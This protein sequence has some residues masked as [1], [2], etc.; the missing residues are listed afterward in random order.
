MHEGRALFSDPPGLRPRPS[1]VEATETVSLFLV[2]IALML[3][4]VK[5]LAGPD[6]HRALRGCLDEW[7]T[8]S[9]RGGVSCF[10]LEQATLGRF[11][12]G[13]GLSARSS[14]RFLRE[15]RRAARR[16]LAEGLRIAVRVDSPSACPQVL[17]FRGTLR[18]PCRFGIAAFNSRKPRL[19][20]PQAPW[21]RALRYAL[22]QADPSR[23][24][25]ISS[26]GTLTY[27]LVTYWNLR[28]NPTAGI[29]RCEPAPIPFRIPLK[30]F[31]GASTPQF[32]A[33]C[34][35][36]GPRCSKHTAMVCRDRLLAALSDIHLVLEV[37]SNGNL[38]AVLREQQNVNPRLQWILRPRNTG[39]ETGAN[40]SLLKRFPETARFFEQEA[41]ERAGRIESLR[42]A[43]PLKPAD[44]VAWKEY[45]YHYTR[46]CPGPW[47]GQSREEYLT[48][49]LQGL[50][51]SGHTALDTLARILNERR[52]R[53]AAR[54]VRGKTPVVSWSARPPSELSAIRR[55]N[56]ALIR[57]TF[58]P[59]GIAVRKARLR[60]LGAKPAV[61]GPPHA[62]QRL[63]V[64]ERHRFQLH[65]PPKHAWKTEREW[66]LAG[67]LQLD[68][69]DETQAF[70]FVPSAREAEKLAQ[71]TCLRLPI[72][73]PE[74]G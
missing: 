53:G 17:F 70:V 15:S 48:A 45:L 46:A 60:R 47:P 73:I 72:V 14:E 59:Y 66:R 28:R 51:D 11:W 58:E 27:D 12:V 52:I 13:N 26:E 61:Y 69:L 16:H 35:L 49:L 68:E 71:R 32:I 18:D 67:D 2:T 7:Q 42:A 37:R 64:S 8:G 41:G 5:T 63:K 57:W 24:A 56:P 40:A 22:E 39:R 4:R 50:S 38:E 6:Y 20:D 65:L 25:W 74:T 36:A 21:L 19:T 9:A 33:T 1:F 30:S 55:W 43:P 34:R 62:F 29:V 23:F 54:L 44:S 10:H 3:S 31:E